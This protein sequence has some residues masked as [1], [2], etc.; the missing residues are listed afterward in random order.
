VKLETLGWNA[1]FES[2]F[3]PYRT[4]N[5]IPGRVTRVDRGAVTVQSEAGT[6]TVSVAGQLDQDG[7]AGPPAVGDW[8][9]MDMIG[10][11]G[12]VRVILPRAGALVRRR[13]G[14]DGRRR[15]PH[16]RPHRYL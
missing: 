5:L 11:H 13:P 12:M 3:A 1:R 14:K 16:A 10:N 8:V 15:Q 2:L 9:G 7:E 4:S 6:A